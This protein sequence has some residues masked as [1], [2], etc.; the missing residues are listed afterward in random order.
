MVI[1]QLIKIMEALPM[2]DGAFDYLNFEVLRFF[3]FWFPQT[4]CSIV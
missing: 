4:V 3:F 2:K 1:I